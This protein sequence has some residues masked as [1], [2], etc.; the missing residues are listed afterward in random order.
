MKLIIDDFDIKQLADSGECFRWNKIDENK[1]RGIFCNSVCEVTQNGNEVLIDGIEDI[2]LINE[3]FD[4]TRDYK[5]IKEFYQQD[6]ILKDAMKFGYGIRILNQDKFETL[7]SFI[8]SANNN[9]PRIKKSIEKISE[10]YGKKIKY[11][12]EEYYAFPTPEELAMAT[13]EE[14]REC[15]VGFRDKYIT[16][17]CKEIVNGDIN[18]EKIS[19]LSIEKA[20]KELLKISGV[21][22]KVADCI[23]LF[24]MK[25]IEAF[26]IDVWVKRIMENLYIKQEVTLKEIEKYSKDKFGEYAGIAQQYLF[27]YVRENP[28]LVSKD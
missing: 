24:S 17:T 12:N 1:Y 22:P 14:L 3:Y 28:A 19:E 10:K 2:D 21:G 18:L 16:K 7:I 4:L 9:I 15:G 23:M 20:K 5:K 27:Y 13:L 8:I 26:P 25:K 6:E 11:K